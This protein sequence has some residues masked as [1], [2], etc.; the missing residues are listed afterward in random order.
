VP[1]VVIFTKYDRLVRT[2]RAE[3]REDYEDLW[4]EE[5]YK[6]SREEAQISLDNCVTSLRDTMK[7]MQIPMPPYMPMSSMISRYLFDQC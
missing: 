4:G 5:L 3:L 2:K 7:R 6:L 1:V